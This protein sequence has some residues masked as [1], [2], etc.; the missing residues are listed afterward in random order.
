MVA[1][2]PMRRSRWRTELAPV[3]RVGRARVARFVG[4]ALG[5][6]GL[7]C[8]VGACELTVP[9]SHF[10]DGCPPRLHG[11]TM[12]RIS[13][14][15]GTYCIDTTEVTNAH[16]LD[17]YNVIQGSPQSAVMPA[18]CKPQVNFTPNSGPGIIPPWPP[19]PGTDIFPVNHVTWCQAYAYC[20]WAGKRL[21]GRIGSGPLSYNVASETDTDPKLSQWLNACSKGGTTIYPY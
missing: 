15:T 19:A 13:T 2:C 20:Q 3:S 5:C 12:V 4:A 1:S 21:C 10:D 17:F 6:A 16:Y 11:P 7:V 18:V 14:D 9:I 8:V